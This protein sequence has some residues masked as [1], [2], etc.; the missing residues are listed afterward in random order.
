MPQK[1][2]KKSEKLIIHKVLFF[3]FFANSAIK[4]LKVFILVKCSYERNL[5]ELSI[6][7]HFFFLLNKDLDEK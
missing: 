5:N 3:F 6:F 7:N 1:K 4:I 2:K